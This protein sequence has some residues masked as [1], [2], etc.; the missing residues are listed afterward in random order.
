MV[1]VPVLVMSSKLSASVATRM[2]PPLRV[3]FNVFRHVLLLLRRRKGRSTPPS[4]ALAAPLCIVAGP[5]RT[6]TAD[7]SST[8][9]ASK[10]ARGR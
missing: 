7:P 4:T 5:V 6:F 2:Q 3:L 10:S 8:L 9:Q 1:L